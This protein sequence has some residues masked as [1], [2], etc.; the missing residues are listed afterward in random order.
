MTTSAKEPERLVALTTSTGRYGR[1]THEGRRAFNGKRQRNHF[2][3]T[4]NAQET[5]GGAALQT[6]A[7]VNDL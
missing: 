4:R 1:E 2:A 3:A 5:F 6:I 7:L